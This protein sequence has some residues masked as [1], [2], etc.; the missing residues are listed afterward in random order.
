M[1][2]ESKIEVIGMLDIPGLEC[3]RR[4]YSAEG[5]APTLSTMQGGEATYGNDTV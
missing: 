3:I 5:I 4:V 2:N 1:I